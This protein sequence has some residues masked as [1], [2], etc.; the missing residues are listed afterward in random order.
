MVEEL[1][2]PKEG[3]QPLHF[4]TAYSRSFLQQFRWI[5]WKNNITYWRL[6]QYNGACPS[7]A[8]H[9]YPCSCIARVAQH[10]AMLLE[11]TDQI[12]SCM[13]MEF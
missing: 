5:L 3:S 13:P 8:W 2:K 7:Q 12:G 6:P 9:V 4:D 11:L 1:K 10:L